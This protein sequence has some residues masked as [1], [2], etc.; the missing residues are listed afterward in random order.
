MDINFYNRK[1]GSIETEKVYGEKAVKW[2]YNSKLGNLVAPIAKGAALSRFYGHIQDSSILSHYKVAP[3]IKNFKIPIEEY[4]PESGLI[5]EPENE[6]YGYS[7]FNSFFTRRFKKG[8]R[9]FPSDPNALGAFSEARYFGYESLDEK[10]LVPV[11][12]QYLSPSAILGERE[13]SKEFNNGPMLL[14][15]LCPVDYHRFHFPDSGEVLESYRIK[16][17]LDS[18]NPVALKEKGDIFCRNE[19]HVTILETKH[20][21]KLAYVEVGA[22][23]VGKIIQTYK[24]KSF[25]HGQEKGMFLF[26][27]S[28][29]IVF[30]QKG[31]WSPTKDITE[32]TK[33]GMEVLV[34]LGDQIGIKSF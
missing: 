23:M 15:R 17:E 20:F 32:N 12:G 33:K 8:M 6:I 31:Q 18:V 25:E 30:G 16:G 34:Q 3:F 7:S 26:G 4:E 11:K 5:H 1:T 24:S 21:G 27:A 9:S 19:R 22:T 13:L 10:E 14:A 28:T 29:V 2:L